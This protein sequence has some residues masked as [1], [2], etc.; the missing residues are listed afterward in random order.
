M[1]SV[2]FKR[3]LV[4][5]LLMTPRVFKSRVQFILLLSLSFY[6][7][8]ANSA[9]ILWGDWMFSP[10]SVSGADDFSSGKGTATANHLKAIAI[11]AASP[12]SPSSWLT[13]NITTSISL[14]NTFKVIPGP[15]ENNG[16]TK[17]GLLS[18]HLVGKLVGIGLDVAYLTGNYGASVS[19]NVNAGFTNWTNPS[20]GT[21]ISGSVLVLGNSNLPVSIGINQLAPITI[22]N[23]Y[24][25]S[26]SLTVN[27]TA[28][29]VYQASSKFDGE[30][31]EFYANVTALSN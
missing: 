15:G 10:Q 24:E 3:I 23:T 17:R 7:T 19:A 16:D 18:G 13:R 25:F 21:A 6:S 30:M 4:A 2:F 28:S 27:A 22:G 29:G 12:I 8:V 26:M 14:T 20:S 5:S 31:G 1:T 11:T 9:E